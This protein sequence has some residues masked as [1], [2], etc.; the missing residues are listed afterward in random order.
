MG[1]A[2][3]L[4]YVSRSPSP[5]AAPAEAESATLDQLVTYPLPTPLNPA[6]ASRR[7]SALAA[8]ER[9]RRSGAIK[10]NVPS[11]TLAETVLQNAER[12]LRTGD[13]AHAATGYVGVIPLYAKAQD[14]A[15]TL[16]RDAEQALA[17]ATPVVSALGSTRP[18]AGRAAAS[19]GR[20][21]SLYRAMEYVVARLAALDAEQVGVAA[22]VA[23]P[24][25]QPAATRAAIGVLLQD[26]ERAVSS[27]RV[28]N[29]RVLMPTM[30]G[31]DV[32]GW[33]AFFRRYTRLTARYTIERLGTRG[34]TA[35]AAVRTQYTYVPAG[36][37]AQ[38]ETR[39]HQTIQCVKTANGWRIGNIRDAP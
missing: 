17:R 4:F 2:L 8:R 3:V 21:E 14:E 9:A 33:E 39:V 10:N 23:P 29:L 13:L 11:L 15:A 34:D 27:E 28:G 26:L 32:T 38:R 19:L 6:L 22:G 16:R 31:K 35:Y 24:S 12:A 36:G 25:P 7:D 18:E 5:A 1:T 20:A 37:G 30:A